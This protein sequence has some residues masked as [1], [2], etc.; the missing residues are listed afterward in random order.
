MFDNNAFKRIKE[1]KGSDLSLRSQNIFDFNNLNAHTFL[2]IF[3]F[4]IG[5]NKKLEIKYIGQNIK[6][7]F[8]LDL[9]NRNLFEIFNITRPKLDFDWD[10][11]FPSFISK[12]NN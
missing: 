1:K 5:F 7:S 3:P 6:N 10:K 8:E 4:C 11:V 9:K 12:H 2:K